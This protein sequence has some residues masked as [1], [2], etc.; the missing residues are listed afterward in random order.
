[1]RMRS[2]M[3]HRVFRIIRFSGKRHLVHES[4]DTL[5]AKE[6]SRAASGLAGIMNV[7]F[8]ARTFQ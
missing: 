5:T 1:M 6:T 2:T 4:D 3:K 7:A 8:T